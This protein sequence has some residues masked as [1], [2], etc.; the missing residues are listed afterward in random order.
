[1]AQPLPRDGVAEETVPTGAV[2]LLP[3][4]ADFFAMP[5]ERRGHWNQSVLLDCREA[6]DTAALS[7]AL[8]D[9]VAHHDALRLRFSQADGAWTQRYAPAE[10]APD[11]LWV[12]EFPNE[13]ERIA[14]CEAAQRS[15]DLAHGPLLRAVALQGTAGQW[16]LLLVIH[17]L[18][19]DGVSW[20][21]L[22]EDLLAAYQQRRSGQPAALPARTASCQRWSEAL[23]RKTAS[24]ADELPHWLALS[25]TAAELPCDDPSGSL[26]IAE[27][28]SLTLIL[29]AD[30]TQALLQHAP[31]AYRTRINDL[32]LT[33]L[34]RVLSRWSGNAR[35]LID[36]ESHGRVAGVDDALDLS[37]TVGWFTTLFPVALDAAG[38]LP[39]AIRAVKEQLRAVPGEGIGFGLLRR[40]GTAEQQAAIAALPKPEV[41]FNYLGQFDASLAEGTPWQP[42]FGNTG[43]GQDASAPL[44]HPLSVSGQVHGGELRLSF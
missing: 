12:R 23:R 4:Q 31:A 42:A 1:V 20:R 13:T 36:L 25:G 15:L 24:R 44:S 32:L 6:P 14:H 40:F 21:I 16:Q 41:V 34:A 17:H 38:A 9:L 26:T 33:A 22:I 37:R 7:L 39:D 29:P 2:P 10:T 30:A 11:L 8:G 43:A 27:R 19:V 35:T 28:D 18:V 3:I 5:M